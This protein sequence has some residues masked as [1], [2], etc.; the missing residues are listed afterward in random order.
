MFLTCALLKTPN[1][2]YQTSINKPPFT[3]KMSIDESSAVGFWE[4]YF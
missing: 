2:R 3:N 1:F 4:D